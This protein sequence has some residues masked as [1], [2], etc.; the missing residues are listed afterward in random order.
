MAEKGY[1]YREQVWA[2][3]TCDVNGIYG[4]YQG[5]GAKTVLPSW[6][7]AKVSMRLVPDQ[8]PAKIARQFTQ[9]VKKVTPKGVRV[10]VE[11][12]PLRPRRS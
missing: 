8:R 4:G 7:G 2:R 5:K 1:T 9:H 11:L 3:P 12:P 6:A 10:E